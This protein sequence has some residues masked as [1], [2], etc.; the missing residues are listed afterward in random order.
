[1]MLNQKRDTTYDFH[2]PTNTRNIKYNINSLCRH[3]AQRSTFNFRFINWLLLLFCLV[4]VVSLYLYVGDVRILMSPIEL[5]RWKEFMLQIKNKTETNKQ[6]H[7]N[8]KSFSLSEKRKDKL[9]CLCIMFI[10]VLCILNE[11]KCVGWMIGMMVEWLD[12]RFVNA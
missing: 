7:P 2:G 12:W 8:Q 4:A 10:C 1:M 6:S 3:R 5:S 11:Y 9:V